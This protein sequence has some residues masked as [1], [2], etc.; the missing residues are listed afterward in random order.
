M[1][2]LSG[3]EVTMYVLWLV[4]T[5]TNRNHIIKFESYYYDYTD[6]LLVKIG[7]VSL[8]TFGNSTSAGGILINI[9]RHTTVTITLAYNNSIA[10]LKE[11]F[12]IFD[13][14]IVTVIVKS[15]SG[16][17][18]LVKVASK[19]LIALRSLCNLHSRV[20]MF[21]EVMCDFR[22]T[23][24]STQQLF[25]IT[26]DED[27][28]CLGKVM[29]ETQHALLNNRVIYSADDGDTMARFVAP[30]SGVLSNTL[31]RKPIAIHLAIV[32]G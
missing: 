22:I 16:N 7:S 6:N 8:L 10:A 20:L 32:A 29:D 31:S 30:T 28:P 5:F 18:N 14:K 26:L 25:S 27:L 12:S 21:D 4:H 11:A 19:F 17:I 1:H 9:A 23:L 3:T 13:Y 2:I 15:V 24:D